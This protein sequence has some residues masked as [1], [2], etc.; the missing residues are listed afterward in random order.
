M[1]ATAYTLRD[2]AARFP[3][4]GVTDPYHG[5]TLDDW[6]GMLP[7]LV[8]AQLVIYPS[9]HGRPE[10]IVPDEA[11]LAREHARV[12]LAQMDD[13]RTESEKLQDRIQSAFA[14]P[15]GA[16]MNQAMTPAAIESIRKT[17]EANVKSLVGVDDVKVEIASTPSDLARGELKLNLKVQA[18]L[19]VM[20]FL[21]EVSA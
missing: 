16:Y 14:A 11:A 7:A 8:K 3:G 9:V 21:T 19:K 6:A 17:V 4:F 18:G 1:R 5:L 15:L 10:V 20:E 2:F 13:E 12:L